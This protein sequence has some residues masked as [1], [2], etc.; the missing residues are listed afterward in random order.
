MNST[1]LRTAMSW[2]RVSPRLDTI[3]VLV[4]VRVIRIFRRPHWAIDQCLHQ[5]HNRWRTA[6]AHHLLSKFTE[7]INHLNIFRFTKFVKTIFLAKKERNSLHNFSEHNS[8]RIGHV[9]HFWVRHSW[10]EQVKS[11][12]MLII[13]S[14][15]TEKIL[16]AFRTDS[17]SICLGKKFRSSI[18]GNN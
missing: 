14:N 16:V 3:E 5:R 10:R 2:I 17:S 12:F 11:I 8:Q 7:V 4:E 13:F 6:M 1:Q 9:S 15:N 18:G